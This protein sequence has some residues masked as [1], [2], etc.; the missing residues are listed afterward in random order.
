MLARAGTFTVFT[1]VYGTA[2]VRT[3]RATKV[4]FPILDILRSV[5]ILVFLPIAL[6]FFIMLGL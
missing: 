4:L 6:T 5:P 2:A 3:R 1:F